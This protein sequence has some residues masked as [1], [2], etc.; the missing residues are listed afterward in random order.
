[1]TQSISEFLENISERINNIEKICLQELELM[2][3]DFIQYATVNLNHDNSIETNFEYKLLTKPLWVTA[4]FEK[5]QVISI[6][7]YAYDNEWILVVVNRDGNEFDEI[8]MSEITI[9]EKIELVAFLKQELY[10]NRDSK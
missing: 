2:K 9:E 3:S 1:M 8:C 7:Y 10:G 4:W 6:K 5:C